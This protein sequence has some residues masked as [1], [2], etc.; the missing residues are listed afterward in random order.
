MADP[1]QTRKDDLVD[2][3]NFTRN[4][5][6]SGLRHVIDFSARASMAL[7]ERLNRLRSTERLLLQRIYKDKTLAEIFE[8]HSSDLFKNS[9]SIQAMAKTNIGENERA[10]EIVYSENKLKEITEGLPDL[11]REQLRVS[12]MIKGVQRQLLILKIQKTRA[13]QKLGQIT[14]KIS[15]EELERTKIAEQEISEIFGLYEIH[16]AYR[17]LSADLAQSDQLRRAY[18]QNN[19]IVERLKLL[20]INF[21]GLAERNSWVTSGQIEL[22]FNDP[23]SDQNRNALNSLIE[24]LRQVFSTSEIERNVKKYINSLFATM[25]N[26]RLSVRLSSKKDPTGLPPPDKS[27]MEKTEIMSKFIQWT[28]DANEWWTEFNQNSFIAAAEKNF[29]KFISR[30][31]GNRSFCDGRQESQEGDNRD[32]AQ[33]E[34]NSNEIKAQEQFEIQTDD[35]RSNGTTFA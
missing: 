1:K 8:K 35:I 19:L 21:E 5:H 13:N 18:T 4:N 14:G 25:N 12:N 24:N 11:I 3:A 29:Y 28:Q 17:A 10:E 32:S 27:Q 34:K 23:G 2:L 22:D 9:E 26:P 20:Q 16:T 7:E 6:P 31:N 30:L 33:Q 15:E